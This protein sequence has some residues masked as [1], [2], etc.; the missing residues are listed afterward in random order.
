[1]NDQLE[2]SMC[3]FWMK[4]KNVLLGISSSGDKFYCEDLLQKMGQNK[5]LMVGFIIAQC[6]RYVPN[7][8]RTYLNLF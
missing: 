2:I 4:N 1:M 7:F 5:P 6:I 8:I 3:Q